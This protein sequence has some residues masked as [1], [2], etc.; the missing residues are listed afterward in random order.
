MKYEA[1]YYVNEEK[2]TVVCTI[3]CSEWDAFDY[4]EGSDIVISV[5]G[6]SKA[7]YKHGRMPSKFVGIAKCAPDDKFDEHIGRLL[8]F[9]RAKGKY[10]HAFMT[11]VTYL[12]SQWDRLRQEVLERLLHYN[13]KAM[14]HQDRRSKE[15]EEYLNK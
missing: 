12:V 4:I 9:N 11:R 14:Y 7:L 2:R 6:Q 8:A 5:P 3:E 1:K 10:D 15:I 13:K